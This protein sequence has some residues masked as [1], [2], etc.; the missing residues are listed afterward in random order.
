MALLSWLP[1]VTPRMTTLLVLGEVAWKLTPGVKAAKSARL[2]AF[3]PC[4]ISPLTALTAPGTS[5]I[6]SSRR[7][8]VTMI[9][10]I[11]TLV[12]SFGAGLAAS[13]A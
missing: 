13:W 5:W 9:S 3:R 4:S 1:V 11:I 12:S 8:A 2:L 7:V 10:P 6:R